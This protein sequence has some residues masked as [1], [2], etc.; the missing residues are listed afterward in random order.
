MPLNGTRFIYFHVRFNVRSHTFGTCTLPKRVGVVVNMNTSVSECVRYTD[1][2]VLHKE[3]SNVNTT[4]LMR[5]RCVVCRAE[6]MRSGNMFTKPPAMLPN[7]Q[8]RT[9][10]NRLVADDAAAVEDA[11]NDNDNDN[12][13][14]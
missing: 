3:E 14:R 8:H 2:A 1:A 5:A 9:A 13:V 11:D 10:H 12:D 4:S 6:R 7:N